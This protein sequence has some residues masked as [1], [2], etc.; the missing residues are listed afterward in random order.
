MI[1]KLYDVQDSW[2]GSG[3][4]IYPLDANTVVTQIEAT[5]EDE[6]IDVHINSCGGFVFDGF[7]IYNALKARKGNVIT[8]CEGIAASIASI[9][10]MAGKERHMA[11]G[12]MLMIH[13]PYAYIGEANADKLQSEA[14]ALNKIQDVLCDIYGEHSGLEAEVINQM[15]NEET[16]LKPDEAITMGFATHTSTPAQKTVI[17]EN[18]FNH[19]FKN[20]NIGTRLYANSIFNIKKED[21][22]TETQDLVKNTNSFLKT[23]GNKFR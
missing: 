1:L 23:I 17:A 6:D 21:M 16:W 11:K 7:A 19:L 20:S 3:I 18:R 2:F 15:V 10:F 4:G 12:S 14:N 13:K 22:S 8:R 9:I 5:P